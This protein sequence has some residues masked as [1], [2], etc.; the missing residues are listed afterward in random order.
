[1]ALGSAAYGAT[2]GGT[3]A[4][5]ATA[6]GS[7]ADGTTA[8]GATASG[9]TADGTTTGAPAAPHEHTHEA[10]GPGA[11]GLTRGA[12]LK[13]DAEVWPERQEKKS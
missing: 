3:T 6:D 4:D 9:T 10:L 7:T 8:G 1:M 11:V 13:H 12:T 5:G 2:T